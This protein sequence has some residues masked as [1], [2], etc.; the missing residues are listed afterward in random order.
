MSYVRVSVRVY[1][2]NS[3]VYQEVPGILCEE[4]GVRFLIE[5]LIDYFLRY[6]RVRSL[7]WMKKICQAVEM[8]LDYMEA[9]KGQFA[10][11][12]AL[13]EAFAQRLS[14]GTINSEGRDPSGLYW[15]GKGTE[16]ARALLFCLG[17]FSAWMYKNRYSSVQ[18]NPWVEA[19]TYEQRL[20]WTAHVNQNSRSLLG[21]LDTAEA[22]SQVC[23]KARAIKMPSNTVGSGG[24]VK[25]FPDSKIRDLLFKG[26]LLPGRSKKDDIVDR[27][28]WRGICIT[29]LLNFGGLRVS[30]PFHLW[31]GDVHPD[32]TDA[33]RAI[34]FVYH[35]TEGVPPSD[36]RGPNG[37]RLA[38]RQAYLAMRYPTYPPRV[39]G[40]RGYHAGWKNPRLD[41][42][43]EK[44]MMV[45]WFPT[46]GG[47]LFMQAYTFYMLQRMREKIDSKEHPFLFVS[48]RGEQHGKPYSIQAYGD[49]LES[50]VRRI[51]L[52]FGRAYGTHKHGH[53]H[54]YGARQRRAETGEIITMRGLHHKS[55]ESQSVY[56]LPTIEEITERLEIASKAMASGTAVPLM[57]EMDIFLEEALHDRMYGRNKR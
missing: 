38:T 28:D 25:A 13:F 6:Y 22:R 32:P 46:D 7:S 27:Y 23:Q 48:F 45:H 24:A 16:N 33:S 49:A 3:G 19:S 20:A 26:F 44:Y 30:E 56:G 52:P 41:N 42:D 11:A 51:G 8:L 54:A 57:S 21:H 55:I 1:I 43:E 53:R 10:D 40:R 2:D 18:L 35:P 39:L 12:E 17:E 50:A 9:N 29:L 47:R 14:S 31:V 5:A 37:R 4:N 15:M 34:V 36:I